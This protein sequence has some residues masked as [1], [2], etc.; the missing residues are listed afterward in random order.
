[1][2]ADY[3]CIFLNLCL[4][5]LPDIYFYFCSMLPS[6]FLLFILYVLKTTD[7]VAAMQLISY[8]TSLLEYIIIFSSLCELSYVI[9]TLLKKTFGNICCVTY[10]A[11]SF[12]RNYSTTSRIISDFICIFLEF[13]GESMKQKLFLPYFTPLVAKFGNKIGSIS[14]TLLQCLCIK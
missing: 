3:Y 7:W 8:T 6:A 4:P 1:M 13:A 10:F 2:D 9:L 12:R 11:T 14:S 5:R